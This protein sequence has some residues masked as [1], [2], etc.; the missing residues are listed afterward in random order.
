MRGSRARLPVPKISIA[1]SAIQAHGLAA[2][3][4]YTASIIEIDAQATIWR[5]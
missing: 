5:P 4:D 2:Y 3:D 1:E